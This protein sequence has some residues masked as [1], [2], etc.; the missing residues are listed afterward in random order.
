MR[1]AP[2]SNLTPPTP[3]NPFPQA[4]NRRITLSAQKTIQGIP[5]TPH[6]Q[7]RRPPPPSRPRFSGPWRRPPTLE[8]PSTPTEPR[9]P[10]PLVVFGLP[11]GLPG[12][13]G[14]PHTSAPPDLPPRAESPALPTPKHPIPAPI[15]IPPI[16]RHRHIPAPRRFTDPENTVRRP[17]STVHRFFLLIWIIDYLINHSAIDKT[18]VGGKIDSSINFEVSDGPVRISPSACTGGI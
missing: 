8:A 15:N 12:P 6:P 1:K 4:S 2:H 18:I 16:S 17:E 5:N 11:R 10:A 13:S 7:F 9:D 3:P 14:Y